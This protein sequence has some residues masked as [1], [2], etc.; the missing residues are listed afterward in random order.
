[1]GLALPG[2]IFYSIFLS[3]PSTPGISE[4]VE[5]TEQF[6]HL[7]GGDYRVVSVHSAGPTVRAKIVLEP[8]A[9]DNGDMHLRGLNALY[10]FQAVLGREQDLGV[11]VG[12]TGE[13][14]VF[15]PLGM[16]FFSAATQQSRFRRLPAAPP[17]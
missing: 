3:G 12:E 15:R 10:D 13:A 1:M 5:I 7:A 16:I 4:A 9:T 11:V 17:E 14:S 2:F 8:P 6:N